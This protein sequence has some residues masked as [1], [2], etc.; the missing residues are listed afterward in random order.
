MD[1]ITQELDIGGLNYP[2][3]EIT[4]AIVLFT[5][6]KKDRPNE[7]RFLLDCTPGN[8]VTEADYTPLLNIKEFIELVVTCFFCSK[9]DR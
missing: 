2:T 4:N 6:P 5:Q 1:K 8:L 3:Q 9:I 7:P